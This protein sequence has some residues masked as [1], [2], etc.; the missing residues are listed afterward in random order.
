MTPQATRGPW[1]SSG[2]GLLPRKERIPPLPLLHLEEPRGKGCFSLDFLLCCD[3][4]GEQVARPG[5]AVLRPT[6]PVESLLVPL[7]L[8]RLSSPTPT[9]PD[10][11]LCCYSALPLFGDCLH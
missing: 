6:Q 3:F 10:S 5:P 2:Q 8:S 11:F 7:S 9:F 4:Q 1:A